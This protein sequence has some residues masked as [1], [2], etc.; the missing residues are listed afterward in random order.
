MDHR[1]DDTEDYMGFTIELWTDEHAEDPRQCD[2]LGK[3]VC[4]H[5]RYKLGD[6]H[7]LSVGDIQELTERNDV[8]WLPLYLYDHSG[9]TMRT[10]SFADPW[11]SGQVGII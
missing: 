1:P 6:K 11:D 7:S 9:I 2:N 3:M 8:L 4:S 10:T 5:R